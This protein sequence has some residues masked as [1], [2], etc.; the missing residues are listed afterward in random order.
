MAGVMSS[1]NVISGKYGEV[2]RGHVYRRENAHH[3]HDCGRGH[4]CGSD[5]YR[6]G[7][8]RG[9]CWVVVVVVVIG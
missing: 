3:R 6:S 5:R 7:R 1:V 9:T 4:G 8:G 2:M